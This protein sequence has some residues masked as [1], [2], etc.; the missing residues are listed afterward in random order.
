MDIILIRHGETEWNK[1]GLCQGISDISL[2]SVGNEQAELLARSLKGEDIKHIY[3][4]DLKRAYET[5][6][7]IDKYHGIGVKIE[8]GFR[9]MNQG[10]FEGV[11]F[12]DLRKTRGELL[13]SWR[14]NPAN[15]RIPNG[16]TLSEVQHRAYLSINN[17][18]EKHTPSTVLVVTHNFTIITLLCKFL[19]RSLDDFYRFKIKQ[20]S[21]HIVR[22]RNGVANIRLFNNTD[23][24]ATL[25]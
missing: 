7:A 10:E 16:E 2:S 9:E 8:P 18:V 25:E 24:L 14:Q 20:T 3:S 4:S 6:K 13:E 19:G 21:K 1:L 12:V 5:A 11:P 23:H 15:F 22:L 17:I